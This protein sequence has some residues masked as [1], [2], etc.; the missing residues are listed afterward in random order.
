MLALGAGLVSFLSPCV[1]PLLP[2]YLTYITGVST[3]Q[4][5]VE[6]NSLLKI[7]VLLNALAFISGFSLIFIL[8]GLSASAVGKLLLRNQILLRKTSGIIIIFLGLNMLGLLK[9]DWFQR[10]KR[11]S[12]IPGKA[13]P[14]NSLLLGMVFSAG[15]TPCIGPIL[16]SILLVASNTANLTMGIYLLSAY[17]LGLAIPFLL[18]AL[19]IGWLMPLIRRWSYLLPIINKISGVLMIILGVMMF[20]NYLARLSSIFYFSPF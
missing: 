14:L 4:L 6:K 8:F 19:S 2:T 12:F 17:S 7:N 16:G 1:L 18:A 3:N 20:T 13:G 11:F 15:W 10:E 9:L 5:S